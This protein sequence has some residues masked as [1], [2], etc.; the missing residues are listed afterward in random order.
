MRT[1]KDFAWRCLK[2]THFLSCKLTFFS[3]HRFFL[4]TNQKCKIRTEK[5]HGELNFKE[6]AKFIFRF[7]KANVSP[8]HKNV[9]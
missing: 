1:R 6:N 4:K 9:I 3:A 7:T 8:S 5:L 2:Q